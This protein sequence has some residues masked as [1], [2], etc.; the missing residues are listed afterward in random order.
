MCDYSLEA[1]AV[2]QH[3]SA[4]DTRHTFLRA[5]A[6]APGD[7]ATAECM[8]CGTKLR[9]EG[10]PE[11]VQRAKCVS[12]NEDVA[13][14]RLDKGPHHDGVRFANG[15]ELTLQE[16]GPGVKGFVYDDL[17]PPVWMPETAE[18]V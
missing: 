10:I 15:T 9:L 18:A 2:G 5:T 12:S 13:F 17:L 16:L 7:P 11:R 4:R 14:V 8:A 1:F 6:F 3:S